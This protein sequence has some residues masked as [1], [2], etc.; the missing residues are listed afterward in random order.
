MLENTV[1]RADWRSDAQN[2]SLASTRTFVV[3]LFFALPIQLLSLY[4]FSLFISP[5]D[6]VPALID[7][8]LS[9]RLSPRP[10]EIN[11]IYLE[12]VN[13]A[14]SETKF[15]EE[16]ETSTDTDWVRPK[17]MSPSKPSDVVV[18]K[19]NELS[20]YLRNGTLPKAVIEQAKAHKGDPLTSSFSRQLRHSKKIKLNRASLFFS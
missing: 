5:S 16:A 19:V 7:T 17:T 3:A 8:H 9:V 13:I 15:K 1:K 14:N 10:E 20:R 4:L 12:A 11:A 18:A 2:S 6:H